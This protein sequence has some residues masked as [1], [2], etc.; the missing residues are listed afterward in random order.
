MRLLCLIFIL[1]LIYPLAIANSKIVAIV[2]DETITIKEYKERLN[3]EEK[4]IG[5]PLDKG[6]IKGLLDKMIEEKI[7]YKQ[8]LKKGLDKDQEF[9]TLLEEARKKI[10]KQLLL[11][12]EVMKKV[13]YT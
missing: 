8:A 9:L 6:E 11:K 1:L 3:Y 10:L 5:K 7:L 12:R 4:R 13:H 2:G